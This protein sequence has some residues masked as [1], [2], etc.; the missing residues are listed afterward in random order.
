MFSG[1]ESGVMPVS[2]SAHS[3]MSRQIRFQPLFL[4]GTGTTTTNLTTIGIECNKVPGADVITIVTFRLVTGCGTK[5]TIVTTG[6]SRQIF[7]VSHSRPNNVFLP[8]PA[9]IKGLLIFC[10]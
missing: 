6:A 9:G 10:E 7:M 3:G 4:G 8:S 5:V 2:Q 1:G